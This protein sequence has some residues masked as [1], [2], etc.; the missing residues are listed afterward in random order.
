MRR[1]DFIA[2]LLA[3]PVAASAALAPASILVRP[4]VFY[5]YERWISLAD[6]Q[7]EFNQLQSQ[8]LDLMAR[9]PDRLVYHSVPYTGPAIEVG[10]RI[11][12]SRPEFPAMTKLLRS[13]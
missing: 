4:P 1:R 7:A 10:P 3:G 2:A 12:P 6:Y 8:R 9:C 5:G 13:Q 11:M